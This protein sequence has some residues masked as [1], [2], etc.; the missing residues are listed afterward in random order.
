M[1]KV[2]ENFQEHDFFRVL[3]VPAFFSVLNK[4]EIRVGYFKCQK[5]RGLESCHYIFF[6]PSI[7]VEAILKEKWEK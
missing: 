6:L 7:P 5:K 4:W 3:K 2:L 1:K